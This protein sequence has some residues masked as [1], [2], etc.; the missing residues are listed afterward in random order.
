[1]KSFSERNPLSIGLTGIG[2]TV[3]IAVAAL[4]F[5][6]LPLLSS[7]ES[8]SAYF[9]DAGGL[10][11]GASVR[12]SGFAVGKVSDIKLDGAKVLVDFTVDDGIRLGEQ[13]EASIKVKSLL[14]TKV[15]DV[16]PRGTG[17][18]HGTIPLERTTSPYQLP[19]ALGDLANT[20]HVLDTDNLSAALDTM[21]QT[22]AST[23]P[24]VKIAVA[25]VAGLSDTINK[26]DVTLRN[27]LINAR[28]ATAVLANR[29]DQVVGLVRDSNALL[30][31][32]RTQSDALDRVSGDIVRASDQLRGF[33]ADNRQQLRPM[34]DKLNGALKIIDN[35]KDRIQEA[36]KLLNKYALSLGES[37]A[38]GPFFKAYIPNL[39]PGQFSQPFIDAAFSDLGLDPQTL[40]PSQRV[41]PPVGQRGTPALPVPYPRTGQG[42]PPRLNLPDAITGNPGDPRYPYREPEPAPA[43][44]GPP[45]G[46]PAPPIPGLESVPSPTP[47]PVYIPAPGEPA[48]QSAVG[49]RP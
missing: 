3:V 39:I 2:I 29:S 47:S 44:G 18:L 8:Y 27:L 7:T 45:P 19:D 28:K 49:E 34:L 30:R 43:P 41:D 25:G 10:N 14:G 21:A 15:I 24:D 36:I 35:R 5:D 12:V 16:I 22:F 48:H 13:T 20:V 1:M 32:L 46:P 23:P 40:S 38:S 9:A 42:G 37:V 33:I 26:R 4:N 11:T 6:K 31:E 17:R